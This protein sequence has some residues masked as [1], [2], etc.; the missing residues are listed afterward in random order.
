VRFGA[1][2]SCSRWAGGNQ[3]IIDGAAEPTRARD[4][5]LR[6]GGLWRMGISSAARSCSGSIKTKD[7]VRAMAT[8]YLG[9]LGGPS[10]AGGLY[11]KLMITADETNPAVK[12]ELVFLSCGCRSKGGL[13][14]LGARALA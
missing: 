6:R 9:E 14:G 11:R 5:G 2:E 4:A 3:F 7:V 8:H 12:A 10:D 1:L 13:M